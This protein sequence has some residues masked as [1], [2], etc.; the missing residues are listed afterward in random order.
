MKRLGRPLFLIFLT[1]TLV[2][3]ACAK[4]STDP[5]A[6]AQRLGNQL[7]CPVC[8]GVPIAGSPSGLAREMMDVVRQQVAAGKSDEEILKY[9]EERYGEWVL[10]TPKAEG[11]NLLVWIL[12]GFVLLGGAAAIIIHLRKGKGNS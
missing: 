1:G 8:R 12:P 10:L 6:R 9:F 3:G 4:L 7:R 11:I 5:E 2:L